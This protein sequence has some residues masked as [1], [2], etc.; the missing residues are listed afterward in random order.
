MGEGRGASGT[1]NKSFAFK[2]QSTLGKGVDTLKQL[3][4]EG[5]EFLGFFW[6]SDINF[7]KIFN[8]GSNEITKTLCEAAL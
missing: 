8:L 3:F 1:Q 4:A 2:N 5:G 6:S 7:K